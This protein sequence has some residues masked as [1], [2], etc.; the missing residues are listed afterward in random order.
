MRSTYEIEELPAEQGYNVK[1]IDY[2]DIVDNVDFSPSKDLSKEERQRLTK[3][4]KAK[5][6]VVSAG[7]LGSTELLLKSKKLNLSGTLGSKFST[8]ARSLWNNKS[9]KIQCRC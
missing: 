2:R 4:I 1:L 8:N 5:R 9:N 7:T 6:V 3:T